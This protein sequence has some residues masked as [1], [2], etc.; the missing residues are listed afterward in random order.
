MDSDNPRY[1]IGRNCNEHSEDTGQ[2]AG[3]K[4]HDEN[5][6]RTRLDAGGIYQR[7]E[8]E[9]VHQLSH[10][11][12]RQKQCYERP[13]MHLHTDSAE[14]QHRGKYR[15]E[16]SAYERSHIRNY[17]HDAGDE[18]DTDCC[19]QADTGK[20]PEA[21]EVKQS[22]AEHL[23]QQPDEISREKMF[24]ITDGVYHFGLDAVRHH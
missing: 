2:V 8:K 6:Q 13:E 9:I 5:L 11:E 10:D 24:D 7:L 19:I 21:Q 18:C 22:Y 1:R 16:H 12:D 17:V 15:S 3:N 14:F 23:Y 4:E 20:C